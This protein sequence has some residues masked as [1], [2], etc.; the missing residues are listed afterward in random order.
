MSKSSFGVIG[1]G[2]M[3]SN[4]GKNIAGKGIS[5][6]VY[7][8]PEGGEENLV[9][10]FLADVPSAESVQGFTE[11]PEFVNSLERPAKILLMIKSGPPVDSV[12]EQLLPLLREG[13][14]IIDG[15]NSHFRDTRRRM[16]YLSGKNI[17]FLGCGISGGA[18]GAR[19]GPSIMPGGAPGGYQKVSAI[20]ES[21]AARDDSGE[22]CCSFIGEDGAGH[23]VK[24]VHNG[25]EYA[26]MQLLA[27]LWHLLS[28][29]KNNEEI[30]GLFSAWNQGELNNYLLEI[31]IQI[32]L[33]KEGDDFLLDL[34]LDKA[35]HKGT[36]SW[37]V[38]AALECG[39]PATMNAA[40]VFARY[41]SFFKE[42]RRQLRLQNTKQ[43]SSEIDASEL[44][45]AYQFARL[46]NHQQGFEL[47]RMAASEY[48]WEVYLSEIARIWTNGCIIKSALMKEL[49]KT[50]S[51][52]EQILEQRDRLDLLRDTEPDISAII[53]EGITRRI[54][55]SA[56][57]A[58]LWYWVSMTTDRLPANLI[59]AQRDFFGG[60][61]YQR[62]DKS[63]DQY[64]HTNWE[65]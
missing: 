13:D 51:A 14:V 31:T 32:L 26:E 8:R 64:F 25:I 18:Q 9:E 50:F 49:V 45:N 35:E 61:T 53:K 55:L 2:V 29:H 62:V 54:P 39:M 63:P 44:R 10:E 1:L 16:Q 65:E 3:G 28:N 4:I 34:I 52:H 15:G 46:I 40:A 22:P 17:H 60:H 59:Q 47:I 58:A 43:T 37:S 42:Q 6:S 38:Q 48:Q 24:M 56:F 21:I 20:L 33:K 41:I 5:L 23:F 7:N 19:T 27:E 36:G 12:I 57:S 30:A 11:L